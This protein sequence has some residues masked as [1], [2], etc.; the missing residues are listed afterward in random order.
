MNSEMKIET[1]DWVEYLRTNISD[2]IGEIYWDC[3]EAE[4][5]TKEDE[6]M[7]GLRNLLSHFIA[8]KN[9]IQDFIQL[10]AQTIIII[11]LKYW[12]LTKFH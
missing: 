11:S 1:V 7:S 4:Y 3:H 10:T 5:L 12:L 8:N 9:T 6:K 2:P